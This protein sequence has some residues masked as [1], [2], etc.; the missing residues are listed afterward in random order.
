MFADVIVD[1]TSSEVDKIFEYSFT[2]DKIVAGSRVVV[3]F[4]SKKIFGIVINVKETSVYPPEKI[5]PTVTGWSFLPKL[6]HFQS[7]NTIFSKR[8]FLSCP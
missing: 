1:I 8:I 6:Q 5:K 2:D 4:G 7:S 3:P